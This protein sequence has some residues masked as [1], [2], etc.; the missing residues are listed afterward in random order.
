MCCC[1]QSLVG[2]IVSALM[3]VIAL[4]RLL[5]SAVSWMEKTER[6]AASVTERLAAAENRLGGQIAQLAY[7]EVI[8]EAEA[9][10]WK[11][12]RGERGSLHFSHPQWGTAGTGD[13]D[14]NPDRLRL[15]LSIGR[16]F[17]MRSG[18][19]RTPRFD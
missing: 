7:G 17:R 19:R 8:V 10:G 15:L 11:V 18:R 3:I 12:E 13:D 9:E 14:L 2:L 1:R 6:Q 16:G 5:N 4:S